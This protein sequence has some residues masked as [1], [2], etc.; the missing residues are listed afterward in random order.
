[1]KLMTPVGLIDEPPYWEFEESD[2]C[3]CGHPWAVHDQAT[4]VK[5]DGGDTSFRIPPN[6]CRA[7]EW[8]KFKETVW[9][10]LPCQCPFFVVIVGDR[11]WYSSRSSATDWVYHQLKL[12]AQ[13][14]SPT[15]SPRP[16]RAGEGTG[17]PS[18][19]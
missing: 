16:D 3:I 4:E 18:A 9:T 10:Q 17:D 11:S 5:S 6:N 12:R 13:P 19:P 1:M 7:S 2:T 15:S 8:V 14:H